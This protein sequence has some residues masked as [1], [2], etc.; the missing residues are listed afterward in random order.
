MQPMLLTKQIPLA[1]SDKFVC[2]SII[3]D[4]SIDAHIGMC[5]VQND[6]DNQQ[7]HTNTDVEHYLFDKL[8]YKIC[9]HDL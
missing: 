4:T 1:G 2:R 5:V 6:I 7:K 9:T 8:F 3:I